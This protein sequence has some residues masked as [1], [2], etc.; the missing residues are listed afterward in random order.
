MNLLSALRSL[1]ENWKR[2]A[3]SAVGV[4]VGSVAIILL[5]SIGL[6]VQKDITSQIDDMGVGVLVVVPGR[7][8]LQMG[9]FN[10]NIGGKSYLSESAAAK[11]AALEG[12]NRVAKWSFGGGVITRDKKEAYPLILATT[13]QWFDIHQVELQQ[14][15]LY[16][17]NEETSQVVV[18]GSIAK[19][20]LFGEANAIGEMIQI[21]GRPYEVI[22]ILKDESQENSLFSM[23]S[24]ANVAYFPYQTL[25]QTEDNVQ[26][27]RIIVQ[28]KGDEDPK[29]LVTNIESALASELE[30]GQFSVLT[31]EDLLSLIFSVFSIL[32]TLVVGLTSIALFVAG[33][34]VMSIMLITVNERTKE[35]GV[36]KA[37]GAR[38][39]DIFVQ[40]LWE[41]VII[42]TT[43]VLLGL[44]S[45][46]IVIALIGTF[47]KIKPLL[48]VPT[49]LMAVAVG[50]GLGSIFGLIP[51]MKAARKDP[52]VALR[53]E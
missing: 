35:I 5:V 17:A 30:D 31:Q 44:L 21:N 48:T 11:V 3:L 12:V 23:M 42:G 47:T 45:S 22:G 52:V 33:F 18:L 16:G 43:G 9:Q 32:T 4:M 26:I 29:A 8:N 37:L 15:R 41:A 50:V 10:P 34:G 38:N 36:R 51:A 25:R 28:V 7:A 19:A 2:A 6:G 46:W 1:S 24:F 40:F 49:V 14:G 53:M 27:D 20:E 13:H 39:S